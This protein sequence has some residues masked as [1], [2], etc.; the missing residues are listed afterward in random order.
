[1]QTEPDDIRYQ[2]GD[3]LAKH[4]RLSL[5]TAN[6]PPE[7]AKA[8]DHGRVAIGAVATIRIDVGVADL[9]GCPRN[10][11]QVLEIHL[12]ADAGAGRNHTEVI[13]GGLP[14]AEELV[15]L[16]VPFE[17]DVDVLLQRLRRAGMI[18]HDGVIDD[19]VHRHQRVHLARVA[20]QLDD[21]VT[22]RGKIDHA[23]YAGE[24]LHEDA[25]G[26]EGHFL[27]GTAVFEPTGDRFGVLHGIARAVFEAEYILKQHL[28]TEREPGDIADRLGRSRQAEVVVNLAVNRQGLAGLQAILPD[29]AHDPE[30][31]SSCG[32]A[33][34]PRSGRRC[35]ATAW[36]LST[37]RESG[38]RGRRDEG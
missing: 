21:P 19:K 35:E 20:T 13:E 17:L 7:H 12:V 16:T 6:A 36:C 11:G 28:E 24:V 26:P 38:P 4:R 34:R 3:R 25:R 1:M 30:P 23:R 9:G 22:H 2:H 14:P 27:V 8:I 37:G 32:P 29:H 15:P 10:L 31:S 18:D 33:G 5:D